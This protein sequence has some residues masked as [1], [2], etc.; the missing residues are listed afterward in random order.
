[1][2]TSLIIP[3]LNE[4][5]C[6]G[7]LLEEV[8]LGLAD[9]VIVVDNGS[10]DGTG[11]IARAAGVIVIEEPRGGYGYACAAGAEAAAGQVIVFMDG[12]GSFLPG[13]MPLLVAPLERGEADLVL[14]TRLLGGGQK[15]SMPAHQLF[16]NQLVT[17]LLRQRYGLA[18][19][20]LGPYRA[21]RRNLLFALDMQEKTYGWPLEMMVKCA[22][23]RAP[24]VEL[25]VTYQ[26]RFGGRS[27]VGGTLR[28]SGLAAYRYFSVMLRYSFLRP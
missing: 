8:P 20:D 4:A 2:R 27:K 9:E 24:I 25:P 19:T 12:D 15:K 7:R 16:G 13:E 10:S 21:I 5:E 26:P 17:W 22:Q 18:V 6:L 23:R 14:G 1:M 3:A 11:D 28:G